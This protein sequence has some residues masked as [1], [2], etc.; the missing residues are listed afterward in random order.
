MMN[1]SKRIIVFSN[2]L[3]EPARIKYTSSFSFHFA[4]NREKCLD[5]SKHFF[6]KLL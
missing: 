2:I 4:K 5:D 6:R 3:T 1:Y